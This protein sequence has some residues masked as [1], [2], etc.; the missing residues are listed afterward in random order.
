MKKILSISLLCLCALVAQAQYQNQ[1]GVVVGGQ[2]GVNYKRNLGGNLQLIATA[3]FGLEATRGSYYISTQ[4]NSVKAN[5][6]TA[7]MKLW[8]VT[9][10]PNLVYNAPINGLGVKEGKL[11]YF[12]GG[13]ISLGIAEHLPGSIAIGGQNVNYRDDAIWGKAGVNAIAGLEY[14]FGEIPLALSIDFRPGYATV[15]H[16]EKVAAGDQSIHATAHGHLFDW[17]LGLGVHY[18]F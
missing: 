16:G 6:G 18:C 8:D 2:N 4:G 3:A 10:N 11:N 13:G 14:I 17:H 1:I 7:E 12:A 5:D 9:V 15:F